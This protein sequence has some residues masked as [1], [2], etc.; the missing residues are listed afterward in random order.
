M[1]SK[2]RRRLHGRCRKAALTGANYSAT[3]AADTRN[4]KNGEVFD[5]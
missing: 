5:A 4:S 1:E 2:M 3:I